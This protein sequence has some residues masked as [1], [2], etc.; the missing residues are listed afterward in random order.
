LA[1]ILLQMDALDADRPGRAALQIDL[2][3]AL[4]DDRVVELADLIALR[5]IRVEV[6][7]PVEPRPGIDLRIQRHAGAYRLPEA[8]LVRHGEHARKGGVDERDLRVR[9]RPEFGGGAGEELG[10]A[11]DLGMDL[12]PDHHLPFARG[13]LDAIRRVSHLRIPPRTEGV[14]T[15]SRVTTTPPPDG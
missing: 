14:R 13:A 6:I 5:Q 11:G 4:A 9:L 7:L 12:Q 10:V 3:F 1:R 15:N 8:L 2:D